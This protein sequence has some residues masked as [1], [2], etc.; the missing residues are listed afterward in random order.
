MSLSENPSWSEILAQDEYWLPA[1]RVPLPIPQM[2]RRHA[3][4]TASWLLRRAKRI[5]TVIY[6]Q[7]ALAFYSHDGGEW[8]HDTLERILEEVEEWTGEEE[9][10]LCE[11]P[12]MKALIDQ[13]LTGPDDEPRHQA[14]HIEEVSF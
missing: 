10:W 13:T 9:K 14:H 6:N 1:D 11:Q 3:A 5:H 12:L 8:A 2:G 4:N 7:C